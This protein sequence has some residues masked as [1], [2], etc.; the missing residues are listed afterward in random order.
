MK[1]K[2]MIVTLVLALVFGNA[3]AAQAG[4]KDLLN[5]KKRKE[6]AKAEQ[7]LMVSCVKD[8]SWMSYFK[9]DEGEMVA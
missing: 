5:P 7:G 3:F 9:N 6:K 4:L 2:G 1:H 8:A